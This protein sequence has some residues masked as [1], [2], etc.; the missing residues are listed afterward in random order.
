L[1][2]PFGVMGR[3]DRGE[4]RG[5]ARLHQDRGRPVQRAGFDSRHRDPQFKIIKRQTTP[6]AKPPPVLIVSWFTSAR[7]RSASIP[8]G[9]R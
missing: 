7:T 5:E 8:H 4:P 9:R 3:F 1:E 6:K 2:I